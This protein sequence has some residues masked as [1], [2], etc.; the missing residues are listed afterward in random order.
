MVAALYLHL[1]RKI[2]EG[3]EVW[4]GEFFDGKK[5]FHEMKGNA[6][7]ARVGEKKQ[8]FAIKALRWNRG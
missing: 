3:G 7:G 5:M 8:D 4:C 1:D 6:E 2:D